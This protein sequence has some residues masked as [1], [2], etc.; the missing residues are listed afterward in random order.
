MLIPGANRPRVLTSGQTDESTQTDTLTSTPHH[1]Y[2]QALIRAIPDFGSV[3]RRLLCGIA[4]P[5]SGI[6]RINAWV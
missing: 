5:K 6:A 3:L 2:T 1:P 4:L